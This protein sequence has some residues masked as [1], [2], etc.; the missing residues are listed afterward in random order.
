MEQRTRVP[1]PL[2]GSLNIMEGGGGFD[3]YLGNGQSIH[4]VTT[5]VPK[6]RG[7]FPSW[8]DGAMDALKIDGLLN[9]LN[10]SLGLMLMY[11]ERFNGLGSLLYHHNSDTPRQWPFT[12]ESP[13]LW[14]CSN[15]NDGTGKYTSDGHW[16]E[17][18]DA[19]KQ[20]GVATML[21]Q[22]ELMGEFKPV[23]TT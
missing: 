10:W 21:K 14:S 17:G 23:Y 6:G 3:K 7:P 16:T 15:I 20:V 22:M 12:S 11:G 18:A 5:I 9:V 4:H 19:N 8:E 2:I 1:W 13:Y